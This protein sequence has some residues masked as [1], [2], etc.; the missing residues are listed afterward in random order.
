MVDAGKMDSARKEL[1]RY[2]SQ[3][4]ESFLP[5]GMTSNRGDFHNRVTMTYLYAAYRGGDL[6]L[7]RKVSKSVKTT[8]SNNYYRS[9]RAMKVA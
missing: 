9:F 4:L 6:E 8:W 5:Y 7:A 1:R 3:V 2:D